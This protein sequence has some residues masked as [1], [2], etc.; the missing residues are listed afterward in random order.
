MI[1]VGQVW[2]YHCGTKHESRILVES[3]NSGDACYPIVV[4]RLGLSA[5]T[6]AGLMAAARANFRDEAEAAEYVEEVANASYNQEPAWFERADVRLVE[7][8]P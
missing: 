1:A 6:K 8:Q 3:M 4:R 2:A 5:E 7:V